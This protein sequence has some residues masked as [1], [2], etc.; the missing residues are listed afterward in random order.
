MTASLT[1]ELFQ[2]YSNESDTTKV[3]ILYNNSK[4]FFYFELYRNGVLDQDSTRIVSDYENDF[5][6]FFSL[7]A[8]YASYEGAE[9]FKIEVKNV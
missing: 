2:T 9:S 8:D 6:R 3:D 1:K 5:V 4:D 7:T